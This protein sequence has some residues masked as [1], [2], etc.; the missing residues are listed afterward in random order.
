[1]VTKWPPT[2]R[3]LSGTRGGFNRLVVLSLENIIEGCHYPSFSSK[4]S[5]RSE[6]TTILYLFGTLR[7]ATPIPSWN[8]F[9]L[10]LFE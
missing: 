10:I 6:S 4:W 3:T 7:M 1:M 8:A 9:L 2:T 5:H